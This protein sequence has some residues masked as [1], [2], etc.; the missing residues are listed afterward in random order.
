MP[1]RPVSWR[2]IRPLLRIGKLALTA[3][4]F[5]HSVEVSETSNIFGCSF[6]EG[7][8]H[9]IRR[10][11]AQYDARPDIS[12]EETALHQYLRYFTPANICSLACS[13][14]PG[15]VR[16]PF[17]APWGAFGP[18][19]Q[20]TAKSPENSRFCGPSTD[21]F[22][23]DEFRR[24]IALYGQVART[25]YRPW[26]TGNGFIEG[27]F[28][29]ANSGAR[30]FVVLQGNHRTAIL[31]HLGVNRLT[32]RTPGH[33]FSS[34]REKDVMDW[35]LVKQGTCSPASAAAVFRMFFEEN[36]EHVKAAITSKLAA[37]RAASERASE[38]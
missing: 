27:V 20:W 2:R 23:R 4:I 26:Q 34:I 19:E 38:R 16:V 5:Q 9:H 36:G 32:V 3:P 24:I 13:G 25:G 22:I 33:G 29:R 21:E 15:D 17:S 35:R 8:W 30:R 1:E 11:L 37:A 10:T 18:Y 12:L 31:A 28:L 6:G 7:G 14:C